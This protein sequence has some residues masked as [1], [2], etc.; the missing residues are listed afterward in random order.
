MTAFNIPQA[1]AARLRGLIANDPVVCEAVVG[2]RIG[3]GELPVIVGV[4]PGETD[5]EVLL[6]GHLYEIGAND[7][8]SGTGAMLEA[9]RL[10]ASMPRPRRRV[11]LQFT[12]ECYGTYAFY[13]MRADLLE[14]TVAGLNVDGVG[15]H[16]SER[17]RQPWYRT[18][19][20]AP[21][22]VDTLLRTTFRLT[23]SLPGCGP[24]AERSHGLS[25]NVLC[26][27]AAGVPMPS[28]MQAP[29]TWHT[30]LDD[31]SQLDPNSI[32]RGAVAAAAYVRWLA[33]A[34]GDDANALAEAAAAE[35]V[36]ARGDLNDRRHAFSADR[37]RAAVLWTTRLG[38]TRA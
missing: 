26:D 38:A 25:D 23:E 17:W 15:E 10:M 12:S 30:S 13:T 3:E 6:N 1:T 29:W 27:P 11:R 34:G 36:A 21:S 33:E 16:H 32:R 24:V 19:A 35:A 37:A 8:A 22:A 14:R 18:P 9:A 4:L 2:G 28:I 5:E 20:A 7:N 31:W